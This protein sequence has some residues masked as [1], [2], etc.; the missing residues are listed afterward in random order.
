MFRWE[1]NERSYKHEKVIDGEAVF[2]QWGCDYQEYESGPGNF[3]TA[4]VE[5]NDGEVKNI[6]VQLIKFID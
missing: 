6:P 3:S 2:H 4:I 5:F 1:K